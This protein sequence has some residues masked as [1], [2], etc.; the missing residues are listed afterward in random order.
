MRFDNVIGVTKDEVL[1]IP[2]TEEP[3]VL[4]RVRMSLTRMDLSST[5]VDAIALSEHT[6]LLCGRTLFGSEPIRRLF[7]IAAASCLSYFGNDIKST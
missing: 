6:R 1:G 4:E 2:V 5:S 3:S 7:C